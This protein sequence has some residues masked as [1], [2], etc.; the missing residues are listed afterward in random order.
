MASPECPEALANSLLCLL[1]SLRDSYITS[2]FFRRTD[3]R[4]SFSFVLE[5][6][7]YYLALDYVNEDRQE[8]F[9]RRF[10][11]RL[12]SVGAKLVLLRVH[13]DAIIE[14][15]VRSTLRSRGSGWA[16]FLSRYGDTEAALVAHFRH[17]QKRLKEL[18]DR[19]LLPTLWIDTTLGDWDSAMHQIIEFNKS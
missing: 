8:A 15:C 19:S 4:G 12:A 14:N 9:V 7:H 3:R 11:S 2:D 18:A 6:F 13:P 10:E 17:R 5:S 16:N 1:E